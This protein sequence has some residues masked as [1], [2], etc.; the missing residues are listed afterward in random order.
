[1]FLAQ[2]VMRLQSAGAAPSEG[3]TGRLEE[4][5][6]TWL[7]AGPSFHSF[8]NTVDGAESL[9]LAMIFG[10]LSQVCFTEQQLFPQGM[11]RMRFV[12]CICSVL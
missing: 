4:D 8:I 7:L 6:L 2:R 3:S 5:S 12:I 11:K 10:N 9:G 1:M